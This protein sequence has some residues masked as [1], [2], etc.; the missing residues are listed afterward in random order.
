MKKAEMP[1]VDAAHAATPEQIR[2]YFAVT[3]LDSVMKRAMS[4]MVAAMKLSSPPYMPAA[5]WDDMD[6]S[7]E[8]YDFLSELVPIY[9]KHLSRDDMAAVLTFYRSEAGQHLLANQNVMSNE[10]QASFQAIGERLGEQVG[11]RHSSEIAA[12]KKK[13][14]DDIANRQNL[15]LTPDPK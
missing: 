2:E 5:V 6:A 3:H 7:M 12:A 11:E 1:V 4:Q 15:N 8:K 13:Y 14:E 10:A 9:Q